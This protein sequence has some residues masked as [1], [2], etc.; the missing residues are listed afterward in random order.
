ML[1]TYYF[2]RYCVCT[3]SHYLLYMTGII[4]R[5]TVL[6][7]W[8]VFSGRVF[9]IELW[10][11]LEKPF[12]WRWS[13]SHCLLC[14][15]RCMVLHILDSLLFWCIPSPFRDIRLLRSCSKKQKS[16]EEKEAGFLMFFVIGHGLSDLFFGAC[17]R[18]SHAKVFE[19]SRHSM[20]MLLPGR[21][22][23]DGHSNKH[24]NRGPTPWFCKLSLPWFIFSAGRSVAPVR[25]LKMRSSDAKMVSFTRAV[26]GEIDLHL[27][28]L[29]D[30]SN[31]PKQRDGMDI[32]TGTTPKTPGECS[33]KNGTSNCKRWYMCTE[34]MNSWGEQ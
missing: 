8:I 18:G 30:T 4:L 9:K 19:D 12:V 17:G 33:S 21:K 27:A 31:M 11:K 23:C 13:T 14:D 3:W 24:P 25:R 34:R 32:D 28:M 1:F 2:F 22:M 16:R 10:N 29:P 15:V 6:Y 20:A 7:Y 26:P 5:Y